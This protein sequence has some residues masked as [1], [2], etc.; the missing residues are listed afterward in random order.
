[1]KDFTCGNISHSNNKTLRKL[2]QI[3]AIYKDKNNVIESIVLDRDV[4]E[5]LNKNLN[6]KTMG[7]ESL[8]THSYCG[9][10]LVCDVQ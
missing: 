9:Y 8:K 1:M 3:I 5:S 2:D 6:T 4:Y 10:R 7:R